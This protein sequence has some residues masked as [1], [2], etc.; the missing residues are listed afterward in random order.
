MLLN[1]IRTKGSSSSLHYDDDYLVTP[2]I[3]FS[4]PLNEKCCGQCYSNSRLVNSTFLEVNPV[5]E[6]SSIKNGEIFFELFFYKVK[7][8]SVNF[9]FIFINFNFNNFRS[10]KINY[11][12]Y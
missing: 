12:I 11:F 3:V 4:L 2:K 5:N 8:T 1:C 6:N 10:Y 9:I 7:L